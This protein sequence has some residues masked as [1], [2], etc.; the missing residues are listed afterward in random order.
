MENRGS[1]IKIPHDIILNS[2]N[3]LSINGI[4]EIVN[5]DENT[6]SLKTVC[7]DLIIDGEDIH[8]NVLNIEKGEIEMNGKI[9][10]LTY[11]DH[12]GNERHSLLS[13]IFR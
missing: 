10:G 8:I 2:R 9:T 4:K 12:I 5:F 7:G 11:F 13:K 6:V 3:K 1:N